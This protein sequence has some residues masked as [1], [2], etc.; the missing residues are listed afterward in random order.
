[1]SDIQKLILLSG[2]V[3]STVALYESHANK[4]R[5]A[6]L[7]FDYGAKHNHKEIPF[8]EHHC[9]VLGVPHQTIKLDFVSEFSSALLSGPLP[10][11]KDD[12]SSTVVPFRNG[13]MLSIAG[14]FAQSMGAKYVLLAAH[15]GDH[16][17]FPDCRTQFLRSFNSALWLGTGLKVSLEIPFSRMTK[18]QIVKKG[19]KLGV[20][21]DKT[22]TCY[23]GTDQPC[24]KC[25]ACRE[26]E[27]AFE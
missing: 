12:Q 19:R 11:A 17:I 26:R 27:R 22:W 7:S 3:D 9:G 2:G 8:A 1:M 25:N 13:I 14:G 18:N 6:A 15:S 10:D 23:A 5:L 4:D 16:A 24:G 21:F 20:D